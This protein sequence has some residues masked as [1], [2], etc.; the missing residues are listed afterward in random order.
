[1]SKKSK[2]QK[3]TSI[4]VGDVIT[5][6][7]Y[8][9]GMKV[10]KGKANGRMV[11]VTPNGNSKGVNPIVSVTA[12]NS[13]SKNMTKLSKGKNRFLKNKSAVLSKQVK[14]IKSTPSEIKKG[15]KPKIPVD[16]TDKKVFGNK[17]GK[18]HWKD[19][20]KIIKNIK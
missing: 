3:R 20:K 14:S 18:L 6:N 13:E 16:V 5:S 12:K 4:Q 9:L 11:V 1:M 7:N 8:R 15:A 10:K 2:K 19:K 17:V